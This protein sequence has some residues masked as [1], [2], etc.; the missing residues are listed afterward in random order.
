[1]DSKKE[2]TLFIQELSRKLDQMTEEQKKQC[3][4]NVYNYLCDQG[5]KKGKRLTAKGV[6]L[7][8]R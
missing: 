2:T 3:F 4:Q 5:V 7:K 6:N 1:M 8:S